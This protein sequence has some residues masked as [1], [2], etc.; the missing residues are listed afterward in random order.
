MLVSKKVCLRPTPE[1]EQL[2]WQSAGAARWSYNY[3]LGKMKDHKQQTDEWLMVGDIRKEMTQLKRTPEYAWMKTVSAN[4]VKQSLRNLETA[5]KRMRNGSG[6]PRFKK[7]HGSA[8]SFYVNYE[9]LH[10]T[11]KG[12]YCEKIGDVVTTEP[13]PDVDKFMNPYISFDGKYWYL[14]FTYERDFIEE[15][16]S[17][18]IYSIDLGLE[19]LATVS[20]NRQFLI[21]I[22]NINKTR[23]IRTL[24]KRLKRYQRKHAKSQKGSKNREKLR[25]Q[26]VN[27]Y[28]TMKN[29][30]DN[31]NHQFTSS[32][33]KTKPE[34]IVLETLDIKG[35]MRNRHL[36]KS[37]QEVK[38]YDIIRQI[39][40]KAS[41]YGIEVYQSD[42]YYPSS[43]LCSVCGH[44]KRDLSLSDRTYECTHCGAV[45]D[46]DKNAT[47]NLYD[48]YIKAHNHG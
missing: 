18:G 30:R 39:K 41:Q 20:F 25:R 33:V 24:E 12:A 23:R 21:K 8:I 1:Q 42:P 37:I 5:F 13:L 46:R 47:Y 28:R 43:K 35:M 32:L 6:F 45:I 14:S 9:T 29:I 17:S 38:W 10:K 15:S 11:D 7:K 48:D 4:V 34:A 2:F 22:G 16:G 19:S 40:Y 26:I 31:H 3:G 44:K 36:S 27:I